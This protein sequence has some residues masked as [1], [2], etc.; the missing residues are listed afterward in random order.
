MFSTGSGGKRPKDEPEKVMERAQANARV[1]ERFRFDQ[2]VDFFA[3][4]DHIL[5]STCRHVDDVI[6]QVGSLCKFY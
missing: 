5:P 1:E 2:T 6:C 3:I 4:R